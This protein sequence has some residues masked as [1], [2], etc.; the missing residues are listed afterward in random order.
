MTAPLALPVTLYFVRHGETDWN[1]QGRLQG[2]RDQPLNAL[3]RVQAEEV[4]ARLGRLVADPGGLDY[5][6]SPLSRARDTMAILRAS[7]G[8][9]PA[10]Y[11]VDAR[12]QELAFGEWEGWTW[13]EVRTRAPEGYRARDRDRWTFAPPGGESYAAAAERV[14]PVIASL[15]R[16]TVLVSH[17]GVA[18]GLLVMLGGI[19]RETALRVDIWQGRVLVFEAGRHRWV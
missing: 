16:D 18:R 3:G 14:R 12:L 9:D 8:L 13:R 7:L 19:K 5:V 17:G 15:I 10:A 1:V 4:G 6:A 11:R 2:Q